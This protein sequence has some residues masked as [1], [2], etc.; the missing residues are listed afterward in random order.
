M[1]TS[2][3][4]KPRHFPLTSL[5]ASATSSRRMALSHGP[6][7]LAGASPCR[8]N[9]ATAPLS[10]VTSRTAAAAGKAHHRRNHEQDQ[11]NEENNLGKLDR[12]ARDAAKAQKS[13]DQRDNQKCNHPTHHDTL[14]RFV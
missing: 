1:W 8:P 2:T 9:D 12:R 4:A 10:V 5:R 3:H 6:M 14:L 11:G 7:A 13:R